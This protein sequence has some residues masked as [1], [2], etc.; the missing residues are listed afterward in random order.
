MKIAKQ[1]GFIHFVCLLGLLLSPLWA[2]G[3]QDSPDVALI[4]RVAGY[5]T[6][7][8]GNTTTVQGFMKVRAGD[9]FSVPEG[10][11]LQ[12]LFLEDGRQ[13]TW[14]GPAVLIVEEKESRADGSPPGTAAEVKYLP[15]KATRRMAASSLPLPG[16]TLQA[17]GVIQT[18]APKKAAEGTSGD[19]R[20]KSGPPAQADPSDLKTAGKLYDDMRKAAPADDLT[21]EAYYLGVLADHGLYREMGR[22]VASLLKKNPGDPTL[23]GWKAWIDDRSSTGKRPG[24]K[25]K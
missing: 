1:P 23:L 11:M 15:S 10:G 4:T 22:I 24:T 21:P 9:R 17:S 5:V 25:K 19:R 13:E 18:M 2:F 7:G 8:G 16:S 14:T 20:K 12:L 6:C 3:Q